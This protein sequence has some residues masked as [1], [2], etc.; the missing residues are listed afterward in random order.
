MWQVW[1]WRMGMRE[2]GGSC[3]VSEDDGVRSVADVKTQKRGRAMGWCRM[4][5]DD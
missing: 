5:K 2:V 1:D 4:D 3:L